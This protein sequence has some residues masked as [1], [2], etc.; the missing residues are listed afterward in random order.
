MSE[1]SCHSYL[2][3]DLLFP[4]WALFSWLY[5]IKPSV[6]HEP[7]KRRAREHEFLVSDFTSSENVV[8]T[9]TQLRWAP[10]LFPDKPTDFLDGLVTMCGAGSPFLRHGYAIHL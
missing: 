7:F 1:Y 8:S 2:F 4:L 10:I 6:T 3:F 5:R 9:P